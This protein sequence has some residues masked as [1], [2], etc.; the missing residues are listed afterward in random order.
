MADFFLNIATTA[1]KA[2]KT[3]KILYQDTDIYAKPLP[4]EELEV[5]TYYENMHL[6]KGKT[7]KYIRFTIN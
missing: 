6:E 2:D 5:K 7:I 1:K 4:M 3:A